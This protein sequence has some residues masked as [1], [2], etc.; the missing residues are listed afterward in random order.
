MILVHPTESITSHLSHTTAFSPELMA[1]QDGNK[2]K[3]Q[4]NTALTDGQYK[5]MQK[6]AS[7]SSQAD[8]KPQTGKSNITLQL[9]DKVEKIL[10]ILPKSEFLTPKQY[11]LINKKLESVIDVLSSVISKTRSKKLAVKKGINSKTKPVESW[12]ERSSEVKN[13]VTA[14]ANVMQQPMYESPLYAYLCNYN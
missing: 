7:E 5:E 10:E 2:A 13:V 1:Y 14:E 4:N 8:S 3:L 9:Q 6:V 12:Q 11:E